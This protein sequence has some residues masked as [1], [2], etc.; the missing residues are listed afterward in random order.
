MSGMK[1][2]IQDRDV[3]VACAAHDQRRLEDLAKLLNTRL[4]AFPAEM[5]ACER[6]A[7][8]ALSLLDETQARAAALVRARGEIERLTDMLVE[9]RVGAPANIDDERGRVGALRAANGA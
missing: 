5:D 4:A 7:L 8:T 6:L 9:E 1:L 3:S 2:K